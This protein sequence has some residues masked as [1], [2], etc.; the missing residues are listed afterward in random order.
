[1]WEN[2]KGKNRRFTDFSEKS[3]L[4]NTKANNR[5][6]STDE[7][8]NQLH[9]QHRINVIRGKKPSLNQIIVSNNAVNMNQQREYVRSPTSMNQNIYDLGPFGSNRYHHGSTTKNERLSLPLEMKSE[10]FLC[11]CLYDSK[12]IPT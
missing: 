2:K 7:Y 8:R 10:Y 12:D 11:N 9:L 3:S 6:N 5:N 4:N 1:M